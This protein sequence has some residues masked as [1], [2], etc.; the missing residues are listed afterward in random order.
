MV[1]LLKTNFEQ[2]GMF[3][4]GQLRMHGSVSVILGDTVTER[5]VHATKV[6]FMWDAI[7][8]R[9]VHASKVNLMWEK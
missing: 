4:T 1:E 8:E 7:T 2:F 3:G 9:E 6:N 5:E